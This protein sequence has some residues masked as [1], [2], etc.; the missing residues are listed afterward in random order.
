MRYGGMTE[1]EALKIITYNGALQLG[2]ANRVFML[3]NATYSVITPEG[4]ASI[5]W[6]D[7][8]RAADAAAGGA[9]CEPRE[10][11]DAAEEHVL[12]SEASDGAVYQLAGVGAGLVEYFSPHSGHV[13]EGP[14]G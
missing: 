13:S 3:E 14:T 4:C 11:A 8:A 10:R 5:L 6:R 9:G 12:L 1:D 7:G 2:V